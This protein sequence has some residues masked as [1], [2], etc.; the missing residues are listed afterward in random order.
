MLYVLYVLNILNSKCVV[1]DEQRVNRLVPFVTRCSNCRSK[2]LLKLH[3]T[4]DWIFE[5]LVH[6]LL[7]V[8]VFYSIYVLSVWPFV[9]GVALALI[10]EMLGRLVLDSDDPVTAHELLKPFEGTFRAGLLF[11]YAKKG[12][13]NV[14]GLLGCMHPNHAR[15]WLQG[16]ALR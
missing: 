10:P 9:I 11:E 12:G 2:Y 5:G 3:W 7:L 1:C 8:S 13:G 14:G 15:V 6:I 4:I 16:I